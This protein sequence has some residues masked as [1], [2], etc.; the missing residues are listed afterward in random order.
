MGIICWICFRIR[1][2]DFT[3]SFKV[4]N[5]NLFES[6]ATIECIFVDRGDGVADAH[7]SQAAAAT[8]G[9]V[10]DIFDGVGNHHR[11]QAAAVSEG[12]GTN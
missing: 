8:E 12:R 9:I 11:C 3:P 6:V 5:F 1:K 10:V 7:R 2:A 4:G